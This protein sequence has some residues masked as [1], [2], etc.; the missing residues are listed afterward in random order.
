MAAIPTLG[1]ASCLGGPG[2]L[3]GFAAELLRDE[4]A[5]RPHWAGGPQLD[6]HMIYPDDRGSAADRLNRLLLEAS[7]HTEEW[8]RSGRPFLVVGGD[9]SCAMGTWAGVLNG[10]SRPEGLG[11]IWLDAHMDAHTFSTSPSGNVHGMPL[12]ALLGRADRRLSA[13]YPATRFIDPAN[14]I[15]IGVRSY[16][17]GEHALLQRAGVRIVFAGEIAD[18]TA[19]VQNAIGELARTCTTIG[20][21]LDLDLIDPE[22]APGVETPVPGGPRADAVLR[23]LEAIGGQPALCGLEISEYNPDN[24]PDRRTLRLMEALIAA[25]FSKPNRFLGSA[26]SGINGS[27][28]PTPRSDASSWTS[29]STE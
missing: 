28:T 19:T 10:L 29:R 13:I 11:L 25:Y 21:S 12:A 22:D 3:C 2:R 9:H 14:L 20:L 17:P 24:D 16:E 6:W 23:A 26:S 5:C 7:R 15:L 18:L 1:I 27:S 4:L 8:S